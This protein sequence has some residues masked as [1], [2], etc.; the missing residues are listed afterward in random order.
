M[1]TYPLAFPLQSLISRVIQK[2]K[3]RRRRKQHVSLLS[4]GLTP[5]VL[6]QKSAL[7][8][9]SGQTKSTTCLVTVICKTH[10]QVRSLSKR[11]PGKKWTPSVMATAPH[12]A[13]RHFY[14]YSYLHHQEKKKHHFRSFS[15]MHRMKRTWAAAKTL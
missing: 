13:F 7:R 12:K 2:K 8:N 3:I 10:A 1:P 9:V 15:H 14:P 4:C 5:A 6:M 11:L